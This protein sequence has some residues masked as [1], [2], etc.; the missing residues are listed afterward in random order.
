[1]TTCRKLS[2]FVAIAIAATPALAVVKRDKGDKVGL[3]PA[4]F[5]P[6]PRERPY[7]QPPAPPREPY[8]YRQIDSSGSPV[9]E[10]IPVN[11]LFTTLT[12]VL[13]CAP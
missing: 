2:L 7:L 8:R 5:V 13:L 12:N 9:I 1:M 6:I 10:C 3:K 4:Y 11:D